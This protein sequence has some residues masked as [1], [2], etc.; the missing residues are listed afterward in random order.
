[1][2]NRT[3][4][5]NVLMVV[6]LIV[7]V[8]PTPSVAFAAEDVVFQNVGDT[9]EF[10]HFTIEAIVLNANAESFN[11]NPEFS[12]YSINDYNSIVPNA[13]SDTCNGVTSEE[14]PNNCSTMYLI[15][16]EDYALLI[17]LGNGPTATA[18]NHGEDPDDPTVIAKLNE[19]Y[20][21]IVNEL[22]GD[23][24][25][26]IAVTHNHGDHIG[27]RT[28]FE[29]SK[30]I[31]VFFPAVDYN[32]PYFGNNFAVT[33]FTPGECSIGLGNGISV[34]TIWAGGHTAGSTIFAISVPVV[35]YEYDADRKPVSS[36]ATY[37]VFGGDAIGSG[38]GVWLFNQGALEMMAQ[39]LPGVVAALEAYN[40]YND[41]LAE[42]VKSDASI[43]I[44]GGHNWQRVS[45]FGRLNMGLEFVKNLN[46]MMG[47]IKEGKWVEEGYE[48][49]TEVELLKAGYVVHYNWGIEHFL[50][51]SM[52]YGTNI[53]DVCCVDSN[54][55][56]L[57]AFAGIE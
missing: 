31:E 50:G 23:R 26:K 40:T 45:R 13:Y 57:N 20:L 42:E 54:I 38:G 4:L 36:S 14:F 9:Y 33:T 34:D 10:G 3:R 19:E 53:A 30:G 35:S 44:M 12:L 2:R 7:C 6:S 48:G 52:Y 21:S 27:Y 43:E 56:A 29:T 41:Y 39:S 5:M 1:M 47:L 24:V 32:K 55:A 51:E 46:T 15:V 8:L 18:K 22:I 37:I 16:T 49:K 25:L 11:E 28:A 17:D